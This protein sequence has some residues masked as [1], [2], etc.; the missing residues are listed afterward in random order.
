MRL[1]GYAVSTVRPLMVRLKQPTPDARRDAETIV[2]F[3]AEKGEERSMVPPLIHSA[4]HSAGE[5]R[6]VWNCP[7]AVASAAR[8]WGPWPVPRGGE[9]QTLSSNSYFVDALRKSNPRCRATE[10]SGLSVTPLSSTS[11]FVRAENT[12]NR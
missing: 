9:V 12:C 5:K 3:R 2:L 11:V 6:A 7:R 1:V 10:G 4:L 8:A